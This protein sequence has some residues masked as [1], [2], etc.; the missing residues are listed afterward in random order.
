M[1]NNPQFEII[2]TNGIKLRVAV[3]GNGPLA[4]LVHGWPESWY[5]WRH[6]ITPL[7][8]AGYKVVALDVRGYGGSDKPP[9][10]EA[11]AMAELIKDT[12]GVIDYYDREQ[13][14]LVGHD[15]GAP[16]VWNTACLHPERVRAVATLSV[17][18]LPAGEISAIELWRR[19]YQGR[20][21]YQKYFQRPGVAEAELNADVRRSLRMVYFNLSGDAPK[22][23]WISD[24]PE[25]AK[26]LDGLI[27]PA[28]LPDWLT[29]A[30][31]DYY[32]EQ[33]QA[34]GFATALHRYRCQTL[35]WEQLPGLR[36]ARIR[37][38]ACFLAGTK[39]I[40]L[41][42]APDIDLIGN[43]RTLTD[44][45][46]MCRMIDGAGHWL[47]Q[48]RPQEVNSALLQFLAGLE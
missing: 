16:V 12:L 31:L 44:D 37:P 40:V 26:L 7:A 36:N 25:D 11:Y 22:D 13:A 15:W 30:D 6:Q 4:I 38:P 3:Q 41:S 20:F 48:E 1:S 9:E 18:W 21:F 35:D 32:T 8:D 17:P 47:Q 28:T 33:F 42:F 19:L 24:K 46:R 43:M 5:S 14:I 23:I 29:Q 10:V 2:A 34:N 27:D 45:L 39:E